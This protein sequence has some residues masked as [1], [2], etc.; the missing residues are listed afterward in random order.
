M[1]EDKCRCGGT[2]INIK[3]REFKNLKY[4]LKC[5]KIFFR[6]HKDWDVIINHIL[7]EKEINN[8]KESR[9]LKC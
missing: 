6:K 8:I 9:I 2:T 7:S 1:N 5:E 3:S 4:C